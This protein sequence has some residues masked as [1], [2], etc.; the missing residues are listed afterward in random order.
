MGWRESENENVWHKNVF[1]I[2]FT[3]TFTTHSSSERIAKKNTT[4][5]CAITLVSCGIFICVEAFVLLFFVVFIRRFYRVRALK[6]SHLGE[7]L[8]TRCCCCFYCVPN[9]LFPSTSSPSF[10]SS[11]TQSINQVMSNIAKWLPKQNN[12]MNKIFTETRNIER[13]LRILG[14]KFATNINYTKN[15]ENVSFG[16]C[17]WMSNYNSGR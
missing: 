7:K 2:E 10:L 9:Y 5:K 11:I 1:S 14:K 13:E 3:L 4:K 8:I 6:T 16:R 12:D 17:A 15:P